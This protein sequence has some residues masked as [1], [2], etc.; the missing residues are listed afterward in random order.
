LNF[1]VGGVQTG[2]CSAVITSSVEETIDFIAI[3]ELVLASCKTQVI[4]TK[5]ESTVV[6]SLRLR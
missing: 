4:Q 2:A 3:L 5:N 1:L 6:Y